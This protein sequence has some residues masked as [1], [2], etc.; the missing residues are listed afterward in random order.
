MSKE[1]KLKKLNRLITDWY[2]DTFGINKTDAILNY[3]L[4]PFN[5]LLIYTNRPGYLIGLHGNNINKF[6]EALKDNGFNLHIEFV[7]ITNFI[8]EI[9]RFNSTSLINRI[10][11]FIANIK[12]R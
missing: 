1:E 10:K 3:E 7:E 5:R 2:Y 11:R 12:E 9:K 4:L 6:K 8:N